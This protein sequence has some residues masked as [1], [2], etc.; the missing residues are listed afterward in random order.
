MRIIDNNKKRFTEEAIIIKKI[1]K[2]SK[3][4]GDNFLER[5]KIDKCDSKPKTFLMSNNN[6]YAFYQII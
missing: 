2:N 6:F 1:S 4:V 5:E 3:C